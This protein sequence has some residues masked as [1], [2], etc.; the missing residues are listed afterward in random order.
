MGIF[1]H[2]YGF[3]PFLKQMPHSRMPPVVVLRIAAVQLPHAKREIRL[4]RFDE[5]IIVLVPSGS[6]HGTGHLNAE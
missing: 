2:Q 5:E 3:E 1:L 4:R 6:R